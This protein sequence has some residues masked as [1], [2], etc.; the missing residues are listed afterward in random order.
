[1]E[2]RET[3]EGT[4]A[5]SPVRGACLALALVLAVLL[6][7]C[8]LAH[9]AQETARAASPALTTETYDFGQ[10]FAGL[11][12]DWDTPDGE[13]PK[14]LPDDCTAEFGRR[15][16]RFY[17]DTGI[18][19]EGEIQFGVVHA[20]W[21]ARVRVTAVEAVHKR[22]RDLDY[23]LGN[24]HGSSPVIVDLLLVEVPEKLARKWGLDG[25]PAAATPPAPF[26]QGVPAVLEADTFQALRG[27]LLKQRGVRICGAA[28]VT[29]MSGTTAIARQIDEV[30]TPKLTF[31]D[32]AVPGPVD[33][34]RPIISEPKPA[35]EQ[36]AQP[37]EERTGLGPNGAGLVFEVLP[38]VDEEENGVDLEVKVTVSSLDGWIPYDKSEDTRAPV[39]FSLEF[40]TKLACHPGQTL[41]A[42][43]VFRTGAD[44]ARLTGQP[45]RR[46]CVLVFVTPGLS[47]KAPAWPQPEAYASGGRCLWVS[48]HGGT[49]RESG[50]RH[51]GFGDEDDGDDDDDEPE[52]TSGDVRAGIDGLGRKV[53]ITVGPEGKLFYHGGRIA[54]FGPEACVRR[55][56][57]FLAPLDG[58]EWY[59]SG[60]VEYRTAAARVGSALWMELTQDGSDVR[61][62]LTAEQV[63]SLLARIAADPGSALLLTGTVITPSGNPVVSRSVAR[64]V[65]PE[66]YKERVVG[67]RRVWLPL[68]AQDARE[69]GIVLEMLPTLGGSGERQRVDLEIASTLTEFLG[70]QPWGPTLGMPVFRTSEIE[71]KVL[72]ECGT[73][74]LLGGGGASLTPGAECS[75]AKGDSRILWIVGVDRVMPE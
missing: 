3:D 19:Q 41:V 2:R 5:S 69:I 59:A 38:Q 62:C 13:V 15:F 36:G 24:D 75:G 53:G 44:M 17:A 12:W 7:G 6:P 9:P 14:R 26:A 56:A 37:V 64:M 46:T 60:F 16:V 31:G 39:R 28:S 29:T 32:S 61:R 70:W 8:R 73:Y 1:M 71:T 30:E 65:P 49:A 33:A 18:A 72:L 63:R 22:L 42:G 51:L 34:V 20:R 40:G 58:W 23:A 52:P 48:R 27:L 55:M 21:G 25:L 4:T 10:G 57:G 11:I 43:R 54:Y 74:A 50:A 67:D 47:E 68:L 35:E 45:P 66:G